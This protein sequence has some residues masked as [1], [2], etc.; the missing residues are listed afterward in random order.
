M[1]IGFVPPKLRPQLKKVAESVLNGAMATYVLDLYASLLSCCGETGRAGEVRREAEGQ[2]QAVRSQWG[3]KWFRRA[4]LTPEP[5]WVGGRAALVGT[6]A[7]GHPE[8]F[9]HS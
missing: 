2:R 3:G 4:W 1:F 7:M 6:A 8:R 5:G 9:C